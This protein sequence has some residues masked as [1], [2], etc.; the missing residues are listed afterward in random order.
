MDDYFQLWIFHPTRDA[1]SFWQNWLDENPKKREDVE[2]ARA[3]LLR[4]N[5]SSYSLPAEDIS[6]VWNNIRA[7]DSVGLKRK[8]VSGAGLLFWSAAAAAVLIIGVTAMFWTTS[9]PVTE[10]T[11]AFG[12][13]KTIILPDSSTVILNSNSSLRL[14]ADWTSSVPREVWLNGE[15]FFSVVHKKNNQPFNVRT[16]ENINIEV[17]GTTFNVYNRDQT[18]IVL[19]TGKIQLSLPTVEADEK[20]LMEPGELVEYNEKKYIKRNVDPKVYTAWTEN[21]L[22][23]NR[24]SLREMLHMIKDNYGIDVEVKER[25]LDQT[26]SGSMPVTDA[27]SLLQQIAKAFQLKVVREEGKIFLR[28]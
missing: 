4:L 10:Y 13:T 3:T 24:T 5:F 18:K 23:L 19:N 6:R 7:K 16:A 12:E 26:I 9:T 25:L 21:T 20:I 2:E 27:E 17:L 14:N 1:E 28:E 22:L 8:R 11:T 15:A